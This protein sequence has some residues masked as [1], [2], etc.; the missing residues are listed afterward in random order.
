MN[1][2]LEI[3]RKLLD[4]VLDLVPHEQAAAL[5]TEQAVKRQNAIV[6]AA[7]LAKFGKT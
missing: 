4:L 6:D 2:A 1:A 3:A 7:E 5:L